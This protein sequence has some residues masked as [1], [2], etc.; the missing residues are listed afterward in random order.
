MVCYLILYM[1]EKPPTRRWSNYAYY[2]TDVGE[3]EGGMVPS[4][5][6]SGNRE[7]T[8]GM[9]FNPLTCQPYNLYICT[10]P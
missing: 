7:E 3:D 10:I 5:S 8:N 6:S 2:H 4:M 9:L 1:S